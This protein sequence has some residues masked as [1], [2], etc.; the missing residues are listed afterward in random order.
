MT[1]ETCKYLTSMFNAE[2]CENCNAILQQPKTKF[3][4][5]NGYKNE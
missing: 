1:C 2:V 5:R 4:K 3:E